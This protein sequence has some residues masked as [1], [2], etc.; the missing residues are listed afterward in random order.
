MVKVLRGLVCGGLGL[1]VAASAGCNNEEST[2]TTGPA[3]RP[4]TPVAP[5][6]EKPAVRAAKDIAKDLKPPVV[7]GPEAGHATPR[8]ERPE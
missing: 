2:M 5:N 6:A 3:N 7:V 4:T 1:A 8:E